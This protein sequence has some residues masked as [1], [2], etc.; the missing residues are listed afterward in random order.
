MCVC[1][2]VCVCVCTVYNND[3]KQYKKNHPSLSWFSPFS[4]LDVLCNPYEVRGK[5]LLANG[6]LP[7]RL[8][9]LRLSANDKGN[10]EGNRGLYTDLLVTWHFL[11]DE[12]PENSARWLS[13]KGYTTSH[14]LK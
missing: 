5:G 3:I 13:D 8:R 4:L 14:S 11:T 6:E 9:Q 12:D 2:C 10:N 1:V 7:Q